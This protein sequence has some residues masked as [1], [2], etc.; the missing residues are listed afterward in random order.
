ME[1]QG[2]PGKKTLRIDYRYEG[3]NAS[4][5]SAGITRHQG[6][7]LI[8]KTLQPDGKRFPT[9]PNHLEGTEKLRMELNTIDVSKNCPK[10][11]PDHMEKT[12][13]IL[14][15]S[16][17]TQLANYTLGAKMILHPFNQIWM[18]LKP[19][20][21]GSKIEDKIMAMDQPMMRHYLSLFKACPSNKEL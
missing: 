9:K 18:D 2:T 8:Q 21:L 4:Q 13:Q 6:E 20:Y 7:T 5:I 1:M 11:I 19:I 15:D 12:R 3:Y 10:L 17:V 16:L 14:V